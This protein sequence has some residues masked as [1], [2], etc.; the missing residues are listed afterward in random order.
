[1]TT[2]NIGLLHPGEMGAAVAVT[3]KNGGH[4][5][6]WASGGRGAA[7]RRRAESA[8]L[9]DAG[10]IAELCGQCEVLVSV[11][12]PEF[13]EALAQETAS[14]GFRGLYVD[15]NAIS[16]KRA[17]MIARIME[18]SG[19]HFVDAS[20]I[21]LPP[22]K[23]GESWIYFSGRHAE[24]AAAHFSA[25]PLEAE[26]L[27]GDIGKASALKMAFAAHTKGIAALRA[28]VLGAASE[29][30]VL[31]DL[32]RHWERTGTT[33]A[34]VKASVEHVAPKAWRF[35]AEMREIAA[36]FQAAGMP[37]GFHE[38]AAEIFAR[39]APFKSAEQ[40]ALEDA[41]EQLS[42]DRR[43]SDSRGRAHSSRTA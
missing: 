19:I 36:T 28:A 29:L 25:G 30:G 20:I 15:A 41:I 35:V 11:C 16:P 9:Q 34:Q 26:V 1:M 27:A 38:A 5:V 42:Y 13:A 17:A 24:E 7:T 40:V 32:E 37:T 6:W 12:P 14:L 21:G 8:G 33:M 39:L 4:E 23:R 10:T 2:K 3:L 31:R 22:R 43:N 18:D